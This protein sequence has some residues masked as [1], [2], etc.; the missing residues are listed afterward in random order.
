M[1][2]ISGNVLLSVPRDVVMDVKSVMYECLGLV[3]FVVFF[4]SMLISFGFVYHA[5]AWRLE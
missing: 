2:G 3:C 1:W 5:R 4:F